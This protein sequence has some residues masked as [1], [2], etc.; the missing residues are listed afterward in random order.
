MR[1]DTKTS[2]VNLGGPAAWQYHNMTSKQAMSAGW[3]PRAFIDMAAEVT[4]QKDR[5]HGFANSGEGETTT[6]KPLPKKRP[7]ESLVQDL[8]RELL[9][10]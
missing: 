2:K 1:D 3:K 7:G 8:L 5:E 6:G 10:D 4:D 9:E